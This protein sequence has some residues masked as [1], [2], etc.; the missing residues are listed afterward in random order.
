MESSQGE[1]QA[2]FQMTAYF[3]T[4][5]RALLSWSSPF[6]RE[7][8]IPYLLNTLAMIIIPYPEP[9]DRISSTPTIITS[10]T[11]NYFLITDYR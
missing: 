5:L 9:T 8:T 4:G 1:S 11:G 10:A 6:K 2:Y 3:L 7:H